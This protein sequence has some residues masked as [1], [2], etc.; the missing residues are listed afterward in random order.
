MNIALIGFGAIGRTLYS[1]AGQERGWR[2]NAVISSQRSVEKIR[3]IVPENVE[4]VTAVKD[5]RSTP[6]MV[7][8]CAGHNAVA[9]HG[10]AVLHLGWPLLI[11]SVGALT[12]RALYAD[13]KTAAE[14]YGARIRLPA[15]ALAG[16]DGVAAARQTGLDKVTLTSR[17]PP[18]AWKDTP[19]EKVVD[20]D[21]LC[22]AK[23][24]YE[25]PARR[26]AIDYPKNVNT[27]ATVSLAGVGFDRTRVRLF[28]D[29]T[30]SSNCHQ[31]IAEGSFGRL[32]IAVEN[33]P[34][35]DNPK[36]SMMA[37]LSIL[38]CLDN[39]CASIVI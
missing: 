8:E 11:V 22:E 25:G 26:A 7:V 36:T 28:A 23:L 24:I 38:R 21:N 30:I 31:V 17:K 19:A 29:P 6:D 16:I 14:K 20:L 3:K 9:M 12:D 2:V 32:E 39:A 37:V 1:H 5:L 15:G 4:V 10:L 33:K 13:L 18:R 35:P 34:H 27:A